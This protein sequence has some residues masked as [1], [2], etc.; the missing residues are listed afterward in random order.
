MNLIGLIISSET[1]AV[2]EAPVGVTALDMPSWPGQ[3]TSGLHQDSDGRAVTP[4][5]CEAA[6]KRSGQTSVRMSQSALID[7]QQDKAQKRRPWSLLD[8][9]HVALKSSCFFWQPCDMNLPCW[10]VQAI[11]LKA[12]HLPQ[13]VI[14]IGIT[15]FA[16][17]PLPGRMQ[18]KTHEVPNIGGPSLRLKLLFGRESLPMVLQKQCCLAACLPAGL[19]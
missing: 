6:P 7:S 17:Y 4:S 13:K 18:R 16:Q 2:T 1:T 11:C 5:L 15:A 12:R 14:T 10:N 3:F 19:L 8:L 9:D